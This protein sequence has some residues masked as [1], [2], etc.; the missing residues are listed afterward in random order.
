MATVEPW[1]RRPATQAI[2]YFSCIVVREMLC[3]LRQHHF[4]EVPEDL[5]LPLAAMFQGFQQSSVVE[6][7]HNVVK[8]HLRDT[9]GSGMSMHQRW[10]LPHFEDVLGSFERQE[11]DADL[12]DRAGPRTL[13]KACFDALG[14]S[15][16]VPDEL[17]QAIRGGSPTWPSFTPQSAH[18]I[19]AATHL[20]MEASGT[21]AWDIVQTAWL[22]IFMLPGS[23]I[24]HRGSAEYFLVLHTTRWAV[25]LWPCTSEPQGAELTFE[26]ACGPQSDIVWKTVSDID[27]WEVAPVELASPLIMSSRHKVKSPLD[28]MHVRLAGPFQSV[29]VASAMTGFR[30]VS[31]FFLERLLTYLA[32]PPI[33]GQEP[34]TTVLARVE[35][36]LLHL[37]PGLRA[38][39]TA[40]IIALRV[41]PKY[42]QAGSQSMGLLGEPDIM[43]TADDVMEP[44]DKTAARE[45]VDDAKACKVAEVKVLDFLKA[46][47]YPVPKTLAFAQS[48]SDELGARKGKQKQIVRLLRE[49]AKAFLPSAL[50]GG[51]VLQPYPSRRSFQIYY[52][53]VCPPRS[54]CERWG[55]DTQRSE[56]QALTLCLQWAWAHHTSQTKEVCPY[57]FVV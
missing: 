51:V 8:D 49:S 17:L 16:S 4:R 41:A 30:D 54:H 57:E 33:Q 44:A 46:K 45:H 15:P 12:A 3:V 50:G 56:Q 5:N 28:I 24:K 29:L 37:V 7:A 27:V 55:G 18:M 35:R 31:D 38:D 34:P 40:D 42:S 26:I 10:M 36:L 32:V 47:G 9:K 52:P 39:Q 25:M 53:T 23:I 22:S 21:D 14:G 19:P 20:L 13:P 43:A 2:P 6:N 11:I 1:R 48:Y